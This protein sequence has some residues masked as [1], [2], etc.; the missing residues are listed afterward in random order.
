MLITVLCLSLF[1]I[2]GKYI[3]ILSH[4][5]TFNLC[6]KTDIFSLVFKIGKATGWIWRNI[7]STLCM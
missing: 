2:F 3:L 5:L 7:F 4:K 6:F 1:D